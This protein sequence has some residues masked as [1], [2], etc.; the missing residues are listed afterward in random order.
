LVL[1]MAAGLALRSLLAVEAIDPGFDTR[2]IV[3]MNLVLPAMKYKDPVARRMFFE[4]ALARVVSVPGVERAGLVSALPLSN[5]QNLGGLEVRGKTVPGE[6]VTAERR[7]AS[8]GY[9]RALGIPLLAGRYFE[10]SDGNPGFH[11]AVINEAVA[12]RFFPKENPLGRQVKIGHDW[13]TLA[14]LLTVIGLYSVVTYNVA[15]RSREVGLRIALG[16]TRNDVLGM[17]LG[18]ALT[19]TGA[20]IVAGTAIA[21]FASRFAGRFVYGVP[22]RDPITLGAIAMLLLLVTAGCRIYSG[23]PRGINRS[24]YSA[25]A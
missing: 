19:M 3:T 8:E 7:W 17:V 1:L 11:S 18:E 10:P 4:Q 13:L 12:R 15:Q 9:F 24:Q 20:G 16:A 23:P 2:E 22:A 25:Q 21:L 14:L 5:N 6:P